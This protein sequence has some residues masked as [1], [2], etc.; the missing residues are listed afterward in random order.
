MKEI[1]PNLGLV[2]I[3]ASEA[4]R[5]RTVTRKRLLSLPGGERARI[6]LAVFRANL[7]VLETALDFCSSRGIKLYRISSGIFPFSDEPK[8]EAILAGMAPELGRVGERARAL[9]VRLVFHPDPFVVLSSDSPAV[10][11]NSVKILSMHAR[12]LDLLGQPRSSWAAVQLHGGKGGR[13]SALVRSIRE[14]PEEIRSR[15]VLENDERAYSASEILAVCQKAQ[16][17]M[18]FDAHHHI[19]REKLTSYDHPSVAEM[20]YAARR[21]WPD[22]SWQMV[23]ISNGASFFNDPRHSDRITRMPA[24]FREAPWIEVEAKRKEE[25]IEQ[26]MREW[27]A[28]FLTPEQAGG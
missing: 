27:P 9:G 4:V 13:S 22:P 8:G 17:P 7:S 21:T 24:V 2:C 26:L 15:V 25:A 14:L 18:V 3:T 23:H 1:R 20:F 28:T 10:R 6:L 5:Y 19:C 16:V 11:Q 12:I